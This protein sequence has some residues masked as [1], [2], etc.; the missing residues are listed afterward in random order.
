MS[1]PWLLL[2][3]YKGTGKDTFCKTL[4]GQ[5]SRY[6]YNIF[7]QHPLQTELF[8]NATRIAFA[9]SLKEDVH[10]KYGFVADDSNKDQVFVFDPETG[11]LVAPRTLYIREAKR[12]RD[13][14]PDYFTKRALDGARVDKSI[15]ITDFR[16]PNELEYVKKLNPNII[17][18]RIF[19]KS[20]EIPNKSITSE[21]YLDDILTDLVITD[22][23]TTMEDVIK[24][25]PQYARWI[26]Q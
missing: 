10:R 2:T 21:H 12:C 26:F 22:E 15:I 8:T 14:D 11:E 18:A 16:N 9:D 5:E 3:A 19:R 6:T 24:I 20:V 25:F 7:G 13:L 4:Q 23:Q 1:S 17:T